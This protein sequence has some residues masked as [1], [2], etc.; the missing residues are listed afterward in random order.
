[1]Y[2]SGKARRLQRLFHSKSG[3]LFVVPMDHTLTTGPFGAANR[4]NELVGTLAKCGA[5]SVV[6][7]KGR[8][9]Y[10]PAEQLGRLSL[11]IHLSGSTSLSED[12]NDKVLVGSVIN[13]VQMG[14]DAVSIHVN[15]G[16]R[17]EREQLAGFGTVADACFTWGMPL[18][19]M[20][21]ARGES[22]KYPTAPETLAH[23]A[24]I[25]TDLGADIVKTDYSGSPDTM[26]DVV[27]TSSVPLIVAG[28][29][30]R[31]S[32]A[33]VLTFAEQVMQGGASGL[34]VGRNIFGSKVPE[35]L[36]R[37]IAE[38]V[39]G[40]SGTAAADLP[41]VVAQQPERTDASLASAP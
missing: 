20:M 30:R 39:H 31:G 1:M 19:A 3:R 2:F 10:L 29:S 26:R 24:A 28:G 15:I 17:T 34:A 32:D 40:K 18:L 21:Y 11:I 37:G 14:A 13:A 23:L 36:I 7:H 22:V 27:T 8:V 33:D 35:Q 4:I 9:R 41:V 16:C 5:D 6:L 25:A 12:S 38:R